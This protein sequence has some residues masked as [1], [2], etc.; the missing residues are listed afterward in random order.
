[1]EVLSM[2]VFCSTDPIFDS[3]TITILLL[4]R[5][6]GKWSVFLG[7]AGDYPRTL[8]RTIYRTR[9][10]CELRHS[11]AAF[12]NISASTS[13]TYRPRTERYPA[14]RGDS[15]P[16]GTPGTAPAAPHWA[17]CWQKVNGIRL[18]DDQSMSEVLTSISDEE[19]FRLPRPRSEQSVNLTRAEDL[20]CNSR[21]I[22]KGE[23][24]LGVGR[25][26]DPPAQGPAGELSHRILPKVVFSIFPYKSMFQL[27][28]Y[29]SSSRWGRS[30]NCKISLP[31]AMLSVPWKYDR[32]VRLNI[33][34]K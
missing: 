20:L 33:K 19:A 16:F 32:S 14:S 29:D 31:C 22:S 21:D 24:V 7:D 15:I 28:S 17:I 10:L 8:E 1:M 11:G 26:K 23:F 13:H 27:L 12:P 30:L 9:P 4:L 5:K 34:V 18:R 3:R 6:Y 2:E 25:F